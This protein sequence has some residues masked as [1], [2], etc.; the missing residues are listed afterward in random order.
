LRIGRR[1]ELS[2]SWYKLSQVSKACAFSLTEQKHRNNFILI[3]ISSHSH[4]Q[5]EVEYSGRP[6]PASTKITQ[7]RTGLGE[8]LPNSGDLLTNSDRRVT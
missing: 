4:D 3:I 1:Q 6:Q 7:Q 2:F 5:A 8:H